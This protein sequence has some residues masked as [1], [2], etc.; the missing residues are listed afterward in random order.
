MPF[1]G[2]IMISGKDNIAV[3]LEDIEAGAAVE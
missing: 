2:G 1:K 3:R